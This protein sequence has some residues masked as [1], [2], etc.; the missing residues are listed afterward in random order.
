MKQFWFVFALMIGSVFARPVP[1]GTKSE[2][3]KARGL[4][5]D[6]VESGVGAEKLVSMAA[7]TEK[8]PERFW[9]YANAFILQ[10][11]EGKYAEAVTTLRALRE[12]VTGIPEVNFVNLIEKN[13]GRKAS[14][15]PELTAL[16]K[17]SRVRLG[18]QKLV[19]RLRQDILKSPKNDLLKVQL[20]EALA[21]AGDWDAALKTF[22]EVKGE[23][24]DVARAERT[25]NLSSKTAAF[26]WDYRPCR[27]LALTAAFR[28][29]S[30]G[31]YRELLDAGKLSPIKK[32]LAENRIAQVSAVAKSGDVT[33]CVSKKGSEQMPQRERLASKP[34]T[35]P[36]PSSVVD[37]IFSGL[38]RVPGR[39]SFISKT[40]LSQTQWE[41]VVGTNPSRFKDPDNPVEMVSFDD[42]VEF[43]K[44]LNAFPG[45][46]E[47]GFIFR[48]PHEDEWR[49]AAGRGFSGME[50]GLCA[51]WVK[52]NSLG[53][54]HKVGTKNP[55]EFGLYDMQGNVW[56][57][58]DRA[59]NGKGSRRGG[60][61][62]DDIGG[63]SLNRWV[64]TPS[65]RRYDSCGFRLAADRASAVAG[66]DMK[67]SGEMRRQP[68]LTSEELKKII[69]VENA[70]DKKMLESK[71][72]KG[73]NGSL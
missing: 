54:T 9:L 59:S 60:S 12:N 24:A 2:V 29:H 69:E 36:S 27:E 51:S 30:A 6:L 18:A 26:W 63:C 41:A 13:I 58:T 44:K 40:E 46:A 72:G 17:E 7:E 43:V 49:C 64:H 70:Y 48:L 16:L 32:T 8:G 68:K 3:Q 35:T 11:K 65:H 15:F 67:T 4:I 61:Y 20:G 1:V 21:V 73:G 53:T 66:E 31:I 38:V 5:D 25:K 47:R 10:S 71:F 19:V 42:A 22:A 50:E 52:D 62:C 55:N 28:E 23:V 45:V 37:S 33:E 14:D 57:W 39:E 34:V 56:E